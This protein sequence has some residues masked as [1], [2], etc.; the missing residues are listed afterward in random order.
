MMNE[1]FSGL[2][3]P[4]DGEPLIAGEGHLRSKSGLRE[5]PVVGSIP[6]F[7]SVDNYAADF[8]R[9]WNTFRRTQL[10]SYTGIKTSEQRLSRCMNGHLQ[11]VRNKRVLEAGSGAGRFSEVLLAHSAVLDSFDYSTAVEANRDN[12]GHSGNFLLVQADARSMPFKK[13]EYDY[14]VC[15]GVLQHTPNPEETIGHLWDMVRPGGYLVIDHYIFTWKKMLPPPLGSAQPIY[16]RL[17]LLLPAN[18]RL[19]A[20]T[21]IVDFFFPLHWQV[22]N[23][24]IG[25]WLLSRV[26]PVCFYYDEF[27]LTNRTTL[28][29]WALLD[30]HD[31]TTDVYRHLRT[32]AQISSCLSKLGATEIIVREAGNGVE[33]LCRKPL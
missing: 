21:R 6:R 1:D 2:R 18:H 28:Y 25:R 17:M 22:R 32:T 10:D 14:V 19:R 33:A 7:V 31:S 4:F 11:Q 15:L 5:Y 16:R 9:Q 30:T 23:S 27:G 29:E 24:R 8:G 12:N 26:S 13:G 20:V 3:D